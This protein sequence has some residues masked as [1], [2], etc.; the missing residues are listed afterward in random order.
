M[1]CV[2]LTDGELDQQQ[3]QDIDE[4]LQQVQLSSMAL[5]KPLPPDHRRP[6][7]RR[8][9]HRW[10]SRLTSSWPNNVL[11]KRRGTACRTA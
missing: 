2:D 4:Q 3:L 10:K 9:A 6:L 1:S 5:C 7:Q 8:V 11:C